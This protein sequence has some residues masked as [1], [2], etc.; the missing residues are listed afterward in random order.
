MLAPQKRLGAIVV[1]GQAFHKGINALSAFNVNIELS[2]VAEGLTGFLS[3][4]SM[5][6]LRFKTLI[7]QLDGLSSRQRGAAVRAVHAV[8][9]PGTGVKKHP[10][11]AWAASNNIAVAG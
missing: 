3:A 7:A 11:T 5:R 8:G 6:R 9:R 10:M 1:G 2:A 4:A